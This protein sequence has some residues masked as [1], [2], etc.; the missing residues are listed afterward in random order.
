MRQNR[1]AMRQIFRRVE[2]VSVR[3]PIIIALFRYFQTEINDNRHRTRLPLENCTLWLCWQLFLWTRLGTFLA[4]VVV[5]SWGHFCTLWHTERL[6]YYQPKIL[7]KSRQ[8]IWA[9]PS[10]QS[11]PLMIL[12]F[13]RVSSWSPVGQVS[14][15][16][17]VLK[18]QQ[19]IQGLRSSRCLLLFVQEGLA[20][21]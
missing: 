11:E 19:G 1:A 8:C 5:K 13:C 17:P 15:W 18:P 14:K 4:V 12:P 10:L 21:R 6:A 20:R 9:P 2:L 7:V 3:S 16:R